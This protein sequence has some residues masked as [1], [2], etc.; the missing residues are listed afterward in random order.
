[1]KWLIALL[2]LVLTVFGGWAAVDPAS[3]PAKDFPPMNEHLVH[4]VGAAFLTFGIGLLIAAWRVSWRTPVLTL[5]ALWN[6]FHAVAH[7][8]DM[9]RAATRE[10]GVT[11][12]VEVSALAVVLALLAWWSRGAD[13][14]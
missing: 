3:F 6:A 10:A 2:G 14:A 11:A 9:D 13:R 8:V 1:M 7:I 5:A 12:V 4:D